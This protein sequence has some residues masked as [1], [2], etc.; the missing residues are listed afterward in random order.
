MADLER[1]QRDAETLSI[2]TTYL[3]YFHASYQ[4][5]QTPEIIVP[6]RILAPEMWQEIASHLDL[7]DKLSLRCICRETT[8][9]LS[10]YIFSR[11]IVFKSKERQDE[12]FH[13][14]KSLPA[15]FQTNIERLFPAL[16][17][18]FTVSDVLTMQ[19]N[20][21]PLKHIKD[22]VLR[23]SKDLKNL[24]SLKNLDFVKQV[25]IHP[26]YQIRPEELFVLF[27]KI[28]GIEEVDFSGCDLSHENFLRMK[29]L[30][31]LKK[32]TLGNTTLDECTLQEF[33]LKCRN[34]EELA[35]NG[36][37]ESIRAIR[38]ILPISLNK[39]KRVNFTGTVIP[40]GLVE[41]FLLAAP[42]TKQVI[43]DDCHIPSFALDILRRRKENVEFVIGRED[44]DDGWG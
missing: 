41:Q 8:N 16:N 19:I 39:M 9:A 2:S 11:N 32:L 21:N 37:R 6:A 36:Q 1:I 29:D 5:D 14:I 13:M 35:L 28:P 7:K 43:I 30:P 3:G 34:L 33:F 22:I 26:D 18:Y 15:G 12:F 44:R 17:Q 42:N 25:K 31:N 40:I 27:E 38:N 20:L 4:N 23:F 10:H 24:L